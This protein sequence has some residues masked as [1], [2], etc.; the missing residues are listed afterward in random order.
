MI[1]QPRETLTSSNSKYAMHP[2]ARHAGAC[3]LS[4]ERCSQDDQ[5]ALQCTPAARVLM[6]VHEH[7]NTIAMEANFRYCIFTQ[8]GPSE[9]CLLHWNQGYNTRA[10][11]NCL[12]HF[13]GRKTPRGIQQEIQLYIWQH[14]QCLVAATVCAAPNYPGYI[15]V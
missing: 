4:R 9:I 6:N 14:R 8:D 2:G 11:H 12:S 7:C 15:L 5:P 13:Y 10:H 3:S 1:L